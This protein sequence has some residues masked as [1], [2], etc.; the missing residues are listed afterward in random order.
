MRVKS[1]WMLILAGVCLSSPALS[2]HD[3]DRPPFWIGAGLG[4]GAVQSLQ[5]APS[6]GRNFLAASVEAGYRFNRHWGAGVELGALVPFTGCE[7]WQ[8]GDSSADFAPA[9]TRM[10]AFAEYRPASQGWHVR[11]GAGLS[12][13]CY[14]SHYSKDAWSWIDTLNLLFDDDYLYS[15]GTGAWQCDARHHA[16]GGA[17]SVGYDWP[18]RTLPATMGVRLTAEAADF[19]GKPEVTMP[20]FRHR[21]LMLTLHFNLR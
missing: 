12:R 14:Q 7:Q 2:Q 8:C 13:F 21:A 20:S 11:A 19:A 17:V 4:G 15:G 18:L 3:P 9:F 5:P 6:A 10:F 16:L 1:K